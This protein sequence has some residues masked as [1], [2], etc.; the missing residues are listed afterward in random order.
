MGR[1]TPLWESRP[2]GPKDSLRPDLGAGRFVDRVEGGLE[3]GEGRDPAGHGTDLAGSSGA[4]ETT[5]QIALAIDRI[6][7]RR[8]PA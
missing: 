6:G 3:Q 8:A 1:S 7:V 5:E 2:P 4:E